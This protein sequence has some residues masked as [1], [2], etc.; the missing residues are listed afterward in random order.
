[1]A[2]AQVAEEDDFFRTDARNRS[3]FDE[4][5]DSKIVPHLQ[6]LQQHQ[7]NST[8][9][10]MGQ[11]VMLNRKIDNLVE[12]LETS[13]S[14][15]SHG[16]ARTEHACSN[17]HHTFAT[18]TANNAGTMQGDT[19]SEERLSELIQQRR[20]DIQV[21][22][23]KRRPPVQV[24]NY[25]HLVAQ[26]LGAPVV[27]MST[28]NTCIKDYW[29]EY[30]YGR[31]KP[32]VEMER[33]YGTKWRAD[34]VYVDSSGEKQRLRAFGQ[35]WFERQGIHLLLEYL[36]G[37][38]L[39]IKTET[40][41]AH[42]PQLDETAAVEAVQ[43]LYDSMKAGKCSN[44]PLLKNVN[45]YFRKTLNLLKNESISWEDLLDKLEHQSLEDVVEE[46]AD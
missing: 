15:E 6:Y 26:Q 9:L 7:R 23:E 33:D 17:T 44:R 19:S 2:V 28:S 45:K 10:V 14:M 40:D 38:G 41:T 36:M 29:Q 20:K 42:S 24:D 11:L 34:Y 12:S 39:S 22:T 18:T 5:C 13:Q 35:R 32:L 46:E 31:P 30:K 1:M 4:T 25:H 8:S 21:V 27:N 3:A 16:A 43:T 37:V